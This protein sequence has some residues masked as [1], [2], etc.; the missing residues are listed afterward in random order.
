MSAHKAIIQPVSALRNAKIYLRVIFLV[1]LTRQD[2][3][4]GEQNDFRN[5]YGSER[6]ISLATGYINPLVRAPAIASVITAEDITDLGVRTLGEALETVAGFHVS[7]TRGLNPILSI[8]GLFSELNPEVLVLIDNV[9]ISQ[10]LAVTIATFGPLSDYPL[11][12]IE[13]IEIMRGPGSALYG[14]DAFAG[15]INIVTKT[16]TGLQGTEIGARVGEFDAYEGWLLHGTRL[17]TVH[18]SIGLSG[19]TSNG[20]EAEVLADAQT[21]LDG[22]FGTRA[23]LAPG[24]VNAGRES[25]EA[26]LSAVFGPFQFRA[27]YYGR[28]NAGTGVGNLNSLDPRG[29][30]EFELLSFDLVYNGKVNEQLEVSGLVSYL[31]STRDIFSQSFP[32]G[33]FGGA[34]PEGV[35]D[36]IEIATRRS[37]AE[38]SILWRGFP[39]HI[40]RLGGGF[41]KTELFDID[42]RTNS[43]TTVLPDGTRILRPRAAFSEPDITIIPE[44]DRDVFYGYVQDQWRFAPDWEA[45]AGIRIDGYSDS[46]ASVNPRAALVWEA[47]HDITAKLLYGRAFRAPSF[48]ERLTRGNNTVIEGNPALDPEVI[49]TVELA[50]I[51][52]APAYQASVNV[53]GY[54]IHDPIVSSIGRR[55]PGLLEF[56]NGDAQTG[57]GLEAE[58]AWDITDGVRTRANYAYQD[59]ID[60]SANNLGLGPRHQIFAEWN[61]RFAPSW[62]FNLNGKAVLDRVRP[63]GDLRPRV[64]DYFLTN[65]VLRR[66]RILGFLDLAVS[67]RNLFDADASDPSIDALALPFDIPLPG[68]DVFGELRIHF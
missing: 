52:R 51:K 48:A 9:P 16:G 45:T 33:A 11:T 12:N 15:V 20:Y 7:T 46:S 14:S 54:Q 49:N 67:V 18:V 21:R 27:G 68:R 56:A 41:Y 8:R 43:M 40:I 22:L 55:S 44:T 5:L 19:L 36:E 34:F 4:A 30:N 57:Y 64:D 3:I 42:Q 29:E 38:G 60:P 66:K 50:L 6:T 25:G 28:F 37:L 17:G 2:T 59:S 24:E 63:T 53:F 13:R 35:L 26:R 39:D 1:L 10:G 58:L 65:A 61:W 31:E 32:P 47:R 62:A 23:A